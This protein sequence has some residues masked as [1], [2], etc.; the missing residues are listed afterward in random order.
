MPSSRLFSNSTSSR[1]A[2][3]LRSPSPQ[4]ALSPES[5]QCLPCNVSQQFVGAINQCMRRVK[6]TSKQLRILAGN[7]TY[8][9]KYQSLPPS[10]PVPVVSSPDGEIWDV[11]EWWAGKGGV[12]AQCL[13]VGLTC[14][15]PIT[16][17]TNWCLK[18]PSHRRELLR[19]LKLHKVKTL[20]P[21][22]P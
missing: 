21:K 4:P 22:P 7:A 8:K 17:E 13:Q 10:T 19:L 11:W 9:R 3:H 20:N 5:N 1:N 2:L 14:G 16:H 12:T 18:L 15:P 6:L